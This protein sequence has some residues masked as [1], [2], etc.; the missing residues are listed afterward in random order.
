VPPVV[1]AARGEL[2]GVDGMK[3][4]VEG[5]RQADGTVKAST[6]TKK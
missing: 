2:G 3:V 4:G 6:I 1:A 5:Y